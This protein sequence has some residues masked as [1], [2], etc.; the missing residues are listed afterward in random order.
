M[1]T[2]LQNYTNSYNRISKLFAYAYLEGRHFSVAVL[3][4]SQS[5]RAITIMCLGIKIMI[6]N[7]H[8]Q[9]AIIEK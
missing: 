5:I 7:I 1:I 6:F 2:E 9:V 3:A 8:R 4:L